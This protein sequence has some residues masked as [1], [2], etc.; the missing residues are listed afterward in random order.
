MNHPQVWAVVLAGGDGTRLRSLTQ[1][2]SGEDRPKQ[3]CQVYGGKTL[4]AQTRARLANAIHPERT[5]FVL[6]K[7]HEKFYRSELDDVEPRRLIVQP[8]NKGTTAAVI[9]SLL[10]ITALAGDPVVAFFPTDHHYSNEAGFSAS[11]HR[12]VRVAQYR[13]DILVLLGAEAEHAE[14]EYGWIEPGTRFDSPF[15]SALL[16]VTRFWEKPSHPTAQALFARGCLWNTFVMVGRASTFLA[17]LE[18]TMAPAV[19]E[20]FMAAQRY[21]NHATYLGD[22]DKLWATLTAGDFSRQVLTP[23]TQHLAVLPVGD[24]GWSDLGTPER[25]R[26]AMAQSGLRPWWQESAKNENS[27]DLAKTSTG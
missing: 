21:G 24:I 1:L 17:L 8:D 12:A 2:I 16:R 15:T 13:S 23:S 11:V 22:Q 20:A 4:L 10:R 26:A 14:V 25:V 3:F 6:V 18:N 27:K 7:T 9:C 5:A 19:L